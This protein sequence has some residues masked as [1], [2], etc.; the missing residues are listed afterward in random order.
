[1]AQG[2]MA[3]DREV[4]QKWYKKKRWKKLREIQL[5]RQPYC[6]C[7]HHIG[8]RYPAGVVDHIIAHKGDHKLFWSISNLQS[9]AK[10]CH[11]MF[12]QSQERG[13]HGFDQGVDI[14]GDPLSSDHP[15]Y[16]G[17]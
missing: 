6:Q 5:S 12:K 17:D 14:H 3:V 11:D 15:W 8:T 13:G 1:M 7:P 10:P 9:M 4:Y 16:K 2:D